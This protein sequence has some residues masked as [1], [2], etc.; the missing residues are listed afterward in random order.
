MLDL[1]KCFWHLSPPVSW[2]HFSYLLYMLLLLSELIITVLKV[3][4][5]F[6]KLIVLLLCFTFPNLLFETVLLLLGLFICMIVLFLHWLCFD[7]YYYFGV[8]LFLQ[9]VQVPYSL[10]AVHC[11]F[12]FYLQVVVF[13]Y[14][15]SAFYYHASYGSPFC[16]LYLVNS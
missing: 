3:C 2:P 4:C 10:F 13:T 16:F 1:L 15:I 7:F 14:L 6:F 5:N 12:Y 9:W 11:I 8:I